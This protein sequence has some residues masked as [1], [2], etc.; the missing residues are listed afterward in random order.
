MISCVLRRDLLR[1]L[2][3]LPGHVSR[4]PADRIILREL[5]MEP[6]IDAGMA[7]GEGTGGVLLLPLLDMALRVYH[8]T[9]TFEALGME[10]YTPRGGGR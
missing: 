7:L 2:L 8:G 10:A 6:V 5:G 1:F 3:H 4:E 9:H